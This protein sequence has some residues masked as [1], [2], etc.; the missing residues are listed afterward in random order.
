MAISIDPRHSVPA[1]QLSEFGSELTYD[2]ILSAAESLDDEEL[3]ALE[4][5]I[6]LF[7]TV[8]L[9]GVLMSRLLVSLREGHMEQAA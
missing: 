2:I 4:A 1:Y 7:A 9:V 6:S 3:S 5:E 8:G